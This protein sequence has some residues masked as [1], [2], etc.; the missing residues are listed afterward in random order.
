[1]VRPLPL[2]ILISCSLLSL[3][4]A[5]ISS[6]LLSFISINDPIVMNLTFNA[7]PINIIIYCQ[8]KVKECLYRGEI[9]TKSAIKINQVLIYKK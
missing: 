2:L 6:R 5:S 9:R 7:A 3:L 4:C 8:I 1:M